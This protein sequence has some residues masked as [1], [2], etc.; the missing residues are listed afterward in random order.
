L[1]RKQ[2]T[3]FGALSPIKAVGHRSAFHFSFAHSQ[4]GQCALMLAVHFGATLG[5]LSS[6]EKTFLVVL[7]KA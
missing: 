3:H 6:M 5:T 2:L 4:Q 1:N 7:Q